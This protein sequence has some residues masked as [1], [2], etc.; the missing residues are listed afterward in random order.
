MQVSQLLR[1]S[2][3]IE[4]KLKGALGRILATYERRLPQRTE[5]C[6]GGMPFEVQSPTV[7]TSSVHHLKSPMLPMLYQKYYKIYKISKCFKL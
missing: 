4:V 5:V 7:S 3:C 6:R 2:M 1:V